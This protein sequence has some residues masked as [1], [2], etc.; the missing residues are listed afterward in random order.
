MSFF[1]IWNS[2]KLCRLEMGSLITRLPTGKLCCFLELPVGSNVHSYNV[3]QSD[4]EKYFYSITVFVF[5]CFADGGW[6]NYTVRPCSK[7]CGVGVA[8]FIRTC[9]EPAPLYGGKS[10][11]G[12][13]TKFEACKQADC[14][15]GNFF[16]QHL[17][18]YLL[19]FFS[20]FCS[21]LLFL[22]FSFLASFFPSFHHFFLLSCLSLFLPRFLP[23]FLTPLLSS[24]LSSFLPSFL[25]SSL[26]CLLHSFLTLF[27]PY[28]L[29]PFLPSLL[30]CSIPSL[31]PSFLTF[32]LVCWLAR[33][34][35]TCFLPSFLPCYLP[36]LLQSLLI[37]PFLVCLLPLSYL[38][39]K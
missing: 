36:S 19:S 15:I 24:S 5:P 38:R 8:V 39:C 2:L 4:S 28:F 27:L 34:F 29:P 14:V 3:I 9:S 30:S 31:L 18:I 10:C 37:C 32:F 13:T 1:S 33:T 25:P 23:C 35:L 26:V 7:T 20:K 21:F 11:V 17:S 6:S 16:K 12:S 22:F